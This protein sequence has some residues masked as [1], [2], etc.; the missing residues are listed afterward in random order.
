[1]FRFAAAL[2][3]AGV[4]LLSPT[5]AGKY[6]KKVSIGDAAP[7]FNDLPGTDDKKHSLQDHKDKDVVVVVITCNHC[8]VSLSYEDRIIA[9][10]K[11][12]ADKKVAVVAISVSH[13]EADRMPKMK[14]RASEKGFNFPYLYDESQKIGRAL[15]ASVTPEFFVLDKER[16]IAYMGS[17]DDSISTKTIRKKYVEDAVD[18]LLKG[19]SI[20][21]K[22][23][24]PKGC[25]LEYA[26]R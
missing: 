2:L 12:Y 25:S 5:Q 13:E 11:K 6:N 9:L 15:G 19:E 3:V 23:T 8:P 26:K 17:L 24:R 10:T 22:E 16:K 21:V 4:A 1:M 14:K 18:A 7:T 20:T